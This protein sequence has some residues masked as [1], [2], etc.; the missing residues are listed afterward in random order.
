MHSIDLNFAN[1]VQGINAI[2]EENDSVNGGSA[3]GSPPAYSSDGEAE[4]SNN[5][6]GASLA[7]VEV[8][9]DASVD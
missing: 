2:V 7:A 8:E 3:K 4:Q 9:S 1:Y 6:E 5:Q